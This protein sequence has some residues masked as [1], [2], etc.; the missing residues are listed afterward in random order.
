MDLQ[1]LAWGSVD[2][3]VLAQDRDRWRVLINA[4]M[5]L[6][7]PENA[8]KF[9]TSLRPVS[10]SRRNLLHRVIIIIIIIGIIIF[11]LFLF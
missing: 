7:V 10:C 4:T 11:I 8:G 1:E 3:I 2:W 9:W 5:K 6:R